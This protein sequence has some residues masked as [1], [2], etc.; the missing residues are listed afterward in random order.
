MS[1]YCQQLQWFTPGETRLT[2]ARWTWSEKLE[3][4]RCLWDGGVSRGLKASTIPWS[5]DRHIDDISTGL[6]SR[7]GNIIHAPDWWVKGNYFNGSPLPNVPLDGELWMGRGRWEETMSVCRRRT[8]DARWKDVVFKPWD[9]LPLE[10]WCPEAHAWAPNSKIAHW[11][12]NLPRKENR[13]IASSLGITLVPQEPLPSVAGLDALVNNIVDQGGE[14]I[15]L[16]DGMS[17]WERRRSS[18]I[19]KYKPYDT[20]SGVVV[21]HT[22]GAGR[23]AGV[24]GAIVLR[25]IPDSRILG[26]VIFKINCKGD[27]MRIAPPPLGTTIRFAY[28]GLTDNGI[29]KEARLI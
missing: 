5:R 21:G 4:M 23:N 17:Y 27:D 10:V 9:L 16:C 25:A 29:P 28:R 11:P 20:G 26:S 13:L 19:L 14:G 18:S 12:R 8:P 15:V 24:C 3:G 22:D 7:L 1:E 6:W 2:G